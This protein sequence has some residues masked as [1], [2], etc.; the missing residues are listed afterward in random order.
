MSDRRPKVEKARISDISQLHRLVNYFADKGEM[1][2]RPLSE[3]YE[4][5]RDYFVI[6][7]GHDVLG[8][9]ALHIDWENLAEIKAMAVTEDRQ[10]QGLGR[11][12]VKACIQEAKALGIPTIFCLT[13]KPEFF[14]Q[15]GFRQVDV[16]E[17]PRK[18]W[19]E[20]YRCPKFPNCDEVA[21]IY[22]IK[23]AE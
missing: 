12:L 18:V 23:G 21:M 16:Y 13:Y 9:V 5:V 4:N 2:P 14:A 22:E 3:M 10:G 6:R 17:L 15:L 8:G 11:L 1:L 19:G 20:C 7:N